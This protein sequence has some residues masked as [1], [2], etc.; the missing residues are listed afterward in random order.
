MMLP[1]NRYNVIVTNI[2]AFTYLNTQVFR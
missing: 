2:V 1:L